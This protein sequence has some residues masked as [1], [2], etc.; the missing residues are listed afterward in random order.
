MTEDRS[1]RPNGDPCR[2]GD[3]AH[4]FDPLTLISARPD[5]PDPTGPLIDVEELDDFVAGTVEAS[6][7][8]DTVI[9]AVTATE[10]PA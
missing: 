6:A 7:V 4:H 2:C 5:L 1:I 9:Q 8:S 3:Y 10:G